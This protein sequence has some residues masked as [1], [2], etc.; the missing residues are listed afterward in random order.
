MQLKMEYTGLHLLTEKAFRKHSGQRIKGG[1]EV[2]HL[3][4]FHNYSKVT[5]LTVRAQQIDKDCGCKYF[6]NK[7]LIS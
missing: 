7:Q 2:S 6:K 3:F 4:L 5:L 1:L